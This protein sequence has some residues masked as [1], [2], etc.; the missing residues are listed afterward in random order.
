MQE[1][2]VEEGVEVE[3]EEVEEDE[4]EGEEEEE[5]AEELEG[6]QE[7]INLVPPVGSGIERRFLAVHR[8]RESVRWR[9][10]NRGAKYG[11]WRGEGSGYAKGEGEEAQG[12]E[13][14]LGVDRTRLGPPERS[15]RLGF[16]RRG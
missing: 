16:V 11:E 5:A 14:V 6:E 4:E 3:Q 1:E 10:K 15:V 8:Q 13:G 7:R 12:G 9:W 2:G